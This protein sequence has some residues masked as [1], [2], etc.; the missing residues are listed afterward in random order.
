MCENIVDNSV[1]SIWDAEDKIFSICMVKIEEF[2]QY[3]TK[4]DDI[5]RVYHDKFVSS[6]SRTLNLN[7]VRQDAEIQK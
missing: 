6:T 5:T 3:L 7:S 4:F 2:P 1:P